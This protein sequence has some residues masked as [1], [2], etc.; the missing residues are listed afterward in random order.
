M[1]QLWNNYVIY[2]FALYTFLLL[3]SEPFVA[4]LEPFGVFCS[5]LDPFGAFWS[6]MELLEWIWKN[7]VIYNF[8]LCTFQFWPFGAFWR[9]LETFGAFLEPLGAFW[10]FW[11]TILLIIHPCTMECPT[12]LPAQL[13]YNL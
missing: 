6:L 5:L 13:F 10:S 7:Y 3:L 9:L 2:N 12:Q 8:A 11:S 1:E 4:F